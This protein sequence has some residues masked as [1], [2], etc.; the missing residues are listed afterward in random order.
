MM[1]KNFRI[2]MNNKKTRTALLKNYMYKEFKDYR[3]NQFMEKDLDSAVIVRMDKFD[4]D[5][6]HVF[7]ERW[8]DRCTLV[9][10]L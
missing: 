8:I 6:A 4:W 1:Q 3:I 9:N 7:I 2:A 5:L 10:M